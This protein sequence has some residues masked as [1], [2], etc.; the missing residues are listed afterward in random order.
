MQNVNK[1]KK[2]VVV[3]K[4]RTLDSN[5]VISYKRPDILRKFITD[6]GKIIPRRISGATAAQQRLITKEVKRSRFLALLPFAD[7]HRKEK[8]PYVEALMHAIAIGSRHG[9]AT[10]SSSNNN[11]SNISEVKGE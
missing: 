1:K 2:K 10:V 3:K 7:N 6:R 4:K 8:Q 5:I 11:I 9:S